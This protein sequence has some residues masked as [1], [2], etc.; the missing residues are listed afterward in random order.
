MTPRSSR[1]TGRKAA[2]RATRF[3]S[4]LPTTTHGRKIPTAARTGVAIPD[5][6]TS[7][8][9]ALHRPSRGLPPGM[10][11]QAYSIASGGSTGAKGVEG[12]SEGVRAG[13]RTPGG[14]FAIS[15]KIQEGDI[16]YIGCV[17][18]GDGWGACVVTPL[19]VW[20][21]VPSVGTNRQT[22]KAKARVAG[23]APPVASVGASAADRRRLEARDP[24][25][26]F[27]ILEPPTPGARCRRKRKPAAIGIDRRGSSCS[28]S[29]GLLVGRINHID[30]AGAA[31]AGTTLRPLPP[32]DE[33]L[34][35]AVTLAS[36]ATRQE[37]H[38][39]RWAYDRLS[40]G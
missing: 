32:F 35:G 19:A 8:Q 1:L 29:A 22:S 36:V 39:N 23:A 40:A 11:V 15:E 17:W 7:C 16:Y 24:E 13:E 27:K 18:G 3:I 14:P 38:A 30:I 20:V 9:R 12:A 2:D 28:M 33:L 37:R 26:G 34:G 21:C 31:W 10:P 5:V 25:S 6:P 4:P